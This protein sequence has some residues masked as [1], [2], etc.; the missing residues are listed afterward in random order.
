MDDSMKWRRKRRGGARGTTSGVGGN[1]VSAAGTWDGGRGPSGGQSDRKRNS[2]E[3]SV[4][5]WSG[6]LWGSR[7]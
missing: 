3:V 7:S 4:R 5:R 2:D 6:R 1:C